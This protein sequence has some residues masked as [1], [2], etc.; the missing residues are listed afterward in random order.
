MLQ[1]LAQKNE[2]P[3][4]M[5]HRLS[6]LDCE[7]NYRLLSPI[8]A[9]LEESFSVPLI[10]YEN[11]LAH[12]SNIP[13]GQDQCRSSVE[14][15]GIDNLFALDVVKSVPIDFRCT[16]FGHI[17]TEP[18]QFD[19]TGMLLTDLKKKEPNNEAC[20]L[21]A[22]QSYRSGEPCFFRVNWKVEHKVII[23][24]SI[25]ILPLIN[26]NTGYVSRLF[27]CSDWT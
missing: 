17:N 21:A 14:Y 1:A 20:Y 15:G 23:S 18:Y 26:K 12:P 22:Y 10:V 16:L 7:V 9:A 2:L 27:G 25:V 5:I 19:A 11:W 4:S 6:G 3:P 24:C 8:E 13:A